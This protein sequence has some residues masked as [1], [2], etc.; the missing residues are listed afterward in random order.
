[1]KTR[2]RFLEL[3]LS[4]LPG[5]FFF[6]WCVSCWVRSSIVQLGIIVQA[7]GFLR[8][9]VNFSPIFNTVLPILN[10][11]RGER[12][13][14][15]IR[16]KFIILSGFSGC[17]LKTV[18]RHFKFNLKLGEG[19]ALGEGRRGPSESRRRS[20]ETRTVVGLREVRLRVGEKKGLCV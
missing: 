11:R 15:D 1:M 10:H 3:T 12:S 18:A 8:P 2:V 5:L 7:L 20:R 6:A 13:R 4:F 9:H 14:R 17:G 16:V 19:E